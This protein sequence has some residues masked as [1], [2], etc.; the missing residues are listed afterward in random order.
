[1]KSEKEIRWDSEAFFILTV[2]KYGVLWWGSDR[3]ESCSL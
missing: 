3:Y 1:M 2:V